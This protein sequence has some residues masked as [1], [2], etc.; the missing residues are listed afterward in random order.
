MKLS[1][2]ENMRNETVCM[3]TKTRNFSDILHLHCP[4][5]RI[6]TQNEITHVL[7]IRRMK[8]TVYA[9]NMKNETI[10]M[11]RIRGKHKNL[12]ISANLMSK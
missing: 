2:T 4:F 9:E 3:Q 1:Y 10:R 7:I 11:L 12:N 6:C 5:L 8:L